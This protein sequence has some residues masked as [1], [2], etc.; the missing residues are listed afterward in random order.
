[1]RHPIALLAILA[2]CVFA[3]ACT[4]ETPT[5]PIR[6][7]PGPPRLLLPA[8]NDTLPAPVLLQWDDSAGFTRYAVQVFNGSDERA[9]VYQDTVSSS[10]ASSEMFEDGRT[11]SWRVGGLEPGRCIWSETRSFTVMERPEDWTLCIFSYEG[12]VLRILSV[13]TDSHGQ[14]TEKEM[15]ITLDGIEIFR[16]NGG[17]TYRFVSDNRVHAVKGPYYQSWYDTTWSI[18]AEFSPRDGRL[19]ALD[20]SR[21]HS[22]S[23]Q[24]TNGLSQSGSYSREMHGSGLAALPH[25]TG[26][27]Q[28]DAAEVASLLRLQYSKTYSQRDQLSGST[29]TRHTL[30]AW[31]VEDGAFVR[32][33]FSREPHQRLCAATPAAA[34]VRQVLASSAVHMAAAWPSMR[35]T[36]MQGCAV[37]KSM[38]GM[39]QVS[40]IGMDSQELSGIL[41]VPKGKTPGTRSGILVPGAFKR[42]VP[43]DYFSSIMRRATVRP[44]AESMYV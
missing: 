17:G 32:L 19:E 37:W 44:P 43:G 20:Y 5:P 34:R 6:Y 36:S 33:E 28:L 22:F 26:T 18:Q 27:Y 31:H 41:Q 14:K 38:P 24:I 2:S 8:H 4:D 7:G 13:H 21:T 12:I 25:A 9:V 42:G 23:E 30:L 16:R 39:D 15:E 3:V 10:A 40:G 29:D 35:P 1:M 11:Y